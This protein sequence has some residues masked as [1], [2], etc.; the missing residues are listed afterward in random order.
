MKKNLTENRLVKILTEILPD[1]Y[2][3]KSVEVT[4]SPH[5]T[6][7]KQIN[8]KCDVI[9]ENK[10]WFYFYKDKKNN[11]VL[12]M[13]GANS[14]DYLSSSSDYYMG[15]GEYFEKKLINLL[16]EYNLY[17]HPNNHYSFTIDAI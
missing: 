17:P 14:Y 5:H 13:D 6:L 16:K 8:V 3:K 2:N 7:T 9:G 4:N 10:I 12:D 1:T 15:Y 11:F